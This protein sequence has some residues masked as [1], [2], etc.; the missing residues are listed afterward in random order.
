MAAGN[1]RDASEEPAEGVDRAQDPLVERLRSDPAQPP[2]PTLTLMGFLGDSDRPGLRRLYFTR[3]LD[4]YAEFR[5]DDVV[6][7]APIPA[8]E[9]PFLGEEAT[10]VILRRNATFEYTWTRTA[11]PLDEFDLD[12]R[13]SSMTPRRSPPW[14]YTDSCEK[15]CGPALTEATCATCVGMGGFTCER[16]VCIDY[17]PPSTQCGVEAGCS[18]GR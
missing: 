13:L 8:E 18:P 15:G 7:I 16:T 2:E 1:P 9:Q 6:H 14:I 3:D 10:R 4:Y 11:R 12:V 17:D 5:V